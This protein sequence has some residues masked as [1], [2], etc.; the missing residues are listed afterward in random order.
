MRKTLKQNVIAYRCLE[1]TKAFSH[2]PITQVLA[3]HFHVY[4]YL[5][6]RNKDCYQPGLINI[7][8]DRDLLSVR[9]TVS[10]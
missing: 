7:I 8:A 10:I 1:L 2:D 4:R 5:P 9:I 6:Y 3:F